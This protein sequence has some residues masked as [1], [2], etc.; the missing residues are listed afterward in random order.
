MARAISSW[1][2]EEMADT[3]ISSLTSGAPA[4]LTDEAPVRRGSGNNK[5]TVQQIMDAAA[6]LAAF[7][8]AAATLTDIL[9]TARA[10]VAGKLT[11]QDVLTA[12]SLL[13]AAAPA[14]AGDILAV[15]RAGVAKSLLV[16]DL[17]SLA[18]KRNYLDNGGFEINQ[19]G[20]LTQALTTAYAYGSVD[21]WA[22]KM[23]TSAAGSA[24]QQ[25]PSGVQGYPARLRLVRTGGSALTGALSTAQVIETTDA[26]RLAG[27]TVTLFWKAQAGAQFSPASSLMGVQVTYGTGT[28][29]GLAS[30]DAGTWTGQANALSTTQAITTTPTYYSKTFAMPATATEIAAVFSFTPTGT[31][32]A[33]DALYLI[34]AWFV[35]GSNPPNNYGQDPSAL[36]LL[37]CQRFL[38]V[39]NAI[40]GTGGRWDGFATSATTFFPRLDFAVQTRKNP[41]GLTLSAASDFTGFAWRTN[42][43]GA[44]TGVA[45]STANTRNAQLTVTVGA[46]APTIAAGDAVSL[47]LANANGRIMMTGAEM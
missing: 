13:T 36:Q 44:A 12:I 8:P 43:S 42:G 20:N 38:P 27:K 5:L 41:T 31:A 21:R 6:L 23:A 4:Q 9:H 16:D 47:L 40:A 17:L 32:G 15:T 7:S 1:S 10:G 2:I 11:V 24:I 19:R 46:G 26:T 25:V 33:D 45:F 37:R 39:I 22:F 14:Q 35:E 34:D 29:E 28:D 18:P 3:K 30:F